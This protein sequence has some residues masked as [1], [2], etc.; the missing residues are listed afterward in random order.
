M[1]LCLFIFSCSASASASVFLLFLVWPG[2]EDGRYDALQGHDVRGMTAMIDDPDEFE[3]E[4]S[5]HSTDE[6]GLS[7]LLMGFEQFRLRYLGRV[8]YYAEFYYYL[9]DTSCFVRFIL[10]CRC[11]LDPS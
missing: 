8:Q 6:W 11:D 3:C 10:A 1:H 5:L 4:I 9:F 7:H 2:F